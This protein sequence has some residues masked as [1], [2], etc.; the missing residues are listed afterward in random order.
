MRATTLVLSLTISCGI[1]AATQDRGWIGLSVRWDTSAQ[2]RY[3]I[4]NR[5]TPGGPAAKAGLQPGDIILTINRRDL[6][7]F[8]DLEFL[9][10]VAEQKPGTQMPIVFVRAGKRQSGLIV[11]KDM[12]PDI[13]PKWEAGVAQARE[14]R[15]RRL[16]ERGH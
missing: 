11:V 6:S 13:R 7:I 15:R 10:Y 5:V 4:V 9:L 14:L 1:A 3:V 16:E 12:P 2:Q 8:D